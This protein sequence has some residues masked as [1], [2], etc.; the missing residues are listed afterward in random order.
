MGSPPPDFWQSTFVDLRDRAGITQ[1]VFNV[2][3][4][5]ERTQQDLRE[6]V[7]AVMVK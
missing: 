5:P 7:I 3:D 4:A 1:A 6:Y 2:E